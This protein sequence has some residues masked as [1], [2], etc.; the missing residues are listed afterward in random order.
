V[1]KN[2]LVFQWTN[3]TKGIDTRGTTQKNPEKSQKFQK[4]TKNSQKFQKILK[5][6]R[7]SNSGFSWCFVMDEL[8]QFQN[9]VS[10][11]KFLSLDFGH[12]SFKHQKFE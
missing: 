7:V 3:F 8:K 4:I 2:K 5:N 12:L 6:T 11:K 9:Q 1:I 10:S